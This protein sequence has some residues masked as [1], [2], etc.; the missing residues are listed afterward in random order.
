[1]YNNINI[2]IE[3]QNII[4]IQ[5]IKKLYLKNDFYKILFEK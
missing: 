1:M 2:I 3:D 4:E 5:C